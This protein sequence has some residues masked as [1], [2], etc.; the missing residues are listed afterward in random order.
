MRYRLLQPP[1]AHAGTPVTG[2]YRCNAEIGA[3]L[4]AA[5]LG[6]VVTTTGDTLLLELARARAAGD[7]AIVDSLLLTQ[8]P[9]ALGR[10]RD[11]VLLL[12]HLP[13]SSDPT[14]TAQSRDAQRAREAAWLRLARG[15]LV[16]GQ[17]LADAL[18]AEHD[19]RVA[20]FQPGA[21]DCFRPPV[22]P[23]HA[24]DTPVLVAV[25]TLEP[26]KNQL[27]L[28]EAAARLVAEGQ[29]LRLWLIGDPHAHPDYTARVL[30]TARDVPIELTGAVPPITVA[31]RL[32]AADLFV[33]ASLVESHGMAVAE[34]AACAL[35]IVAVRTGE[36]TTWVEPEMNGLLLDDGDPATLHTALRHALAQLPRLRDQARWRAPLLPS[37]D[38]SFA[39]FLLATGRLMKQEQDSPDA[40]FAGCRLPTQAGD[41]QVH[42]WHPEDGSEVI[43]VQLGDLHGE[44]PPFVRVHSECFTGEVL[45]SLKC[46]CRAQLDAALATIAARSRGAIVYL[47][48]EGRG[49]GLSNKIRAYAEQELGA[50]TILANHR[51]GFPT[52]LRDFGVA[53]RILLASGARRIEVNTNNPDKIAAL[54]AHGIEITGVVPALTPPNAHNIDYLRTKLHELG[55]AGLEAALRGRI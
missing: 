36:A 53:A 19:V 55:H 43:V 21:E 18:A 15:V 32:Q 14:L 37:W 7:V 27:A 52:D 25:G 5:G 22:E 34:A 1:P 47:R 6:G 30:A 20:V 9:P 4:T 29:P 44:P 45:G 2:G 23:R 28:A 42:V 40:P 33:S 11:R 24:I 12:M 39:Q 13:P 49:I 10:D 46:D 17:A 41:F 48:Q 3:R 16:T 38:T 50:D 26:R 35:P 8:D 54:T 31:S 51:I